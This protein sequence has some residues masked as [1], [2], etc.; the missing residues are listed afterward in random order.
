MN[1][2]LGIVGE[3]LFQGGL[4]EKM[5]SA[6]TL[7]APIELAQKGSSSKVELVHFVNENLIA[8]LAFVL[9]QVRALGDI[10]SE[11]ATIHRFFKYLFDEWIINL[12]V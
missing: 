3:A 5:R 8:L 2:Q 10:L 12:S 1:G 9:I 6:H 7:R 11:C 4:E